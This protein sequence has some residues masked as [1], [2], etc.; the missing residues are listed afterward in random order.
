MD[1]VT[2]SGISKQEG[3]G[4]SLRDISFSQ[5]PLQKI[6]IAGETGSGK[7]TLLKIIAGL[8]QA[9][10]GAV[11]I[12]QERVKG[13][14]EKL[15]AG[16]PGI[17]YLSQ[18]YELPGFL[19]VEQVLQYASR[20]SSE[21]SMSLYELCRISHLLKRKTDQLSGGERQRIALARL[22]LS[23]P[24]LL[25]LDE[26]FSNLDM[27]HKSILK[28]VIEDISDRL[29]IS[30]MLVSHDPLDTLSWADQVLI[31][32]AG[33]L[34]QQGSPEQIYRQPVNAYAA[35]LFGSHTILPAEV[36]RAFA[37]AGVHDLKEKNL[38]IRPEQLSLHA[39]EKSGIAGKVVKQKF[40][41]SFYTYQ[42]EIEQTSISITAR[43]Q[44]ASYS[45]GDKVFVSLERGGLWYV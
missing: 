37:A 9:D 38:L 1:L 16:H 17:A 31:M 45:V 44:N 12:E 26:P 34:L 30:C 36:A 27:V 23:S 15:V 22:L 41:G 7:S 6:A 32:Q 18:Q 10:A 20:L 13:P 42:I 43:S 35:G 11:F 4:F 19:R 3:T 5:L 40:Y 14:A 2:V 25:L 24:R 33:Q 8:V 39:D 29:R 28:S 21:E